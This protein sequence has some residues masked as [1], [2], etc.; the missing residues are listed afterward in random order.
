M[1]SGPSKMGG[2]S[3]KLGQIVPDG[4]STAAMP[5]RIRFT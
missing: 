4:G 2:D 3:F 1:V 5:A